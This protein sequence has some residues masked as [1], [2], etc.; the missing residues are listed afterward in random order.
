MATK[1]AATHSSRACRVRRVVS[2]SPGRRGALFVTR[3]YQGVS[4][5][6]EDGSRASPGKRVTN[7]KQS[8]EPAGSGSVVVLAMA[9]LAAL[10]LVLVAVMFT[11]L[12][13]LV[14]IAVVVVAPSAAA[15]VAAACLAPRRG[16]STSVSGQ[17]AG[18]RSS[19]GA[20]VRA[21]TSGQAAFT[22]IPPMRHRSRSRG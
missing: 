21:I 18:A 6:N 12:P 16:R 14:K 10:P 5:G 7:L 13:L 19:L 8:D 2:S 9:A 17:T 11:P 15:L 22:G 1:T 20:A 3:G 4:L